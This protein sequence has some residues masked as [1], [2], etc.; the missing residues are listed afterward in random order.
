MNN[1]LFFR[2]GL[3]ASC[4]AVLYG[5]RSGQLGLYI[6]LVNIFLLL[7]SFMLTLALISYLQQPKSIDKSLQTQ[8]AFVKLVSCLSRYFSSN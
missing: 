2:H 5:G 3:E 6:V 4:M 7:L 1:N 8:C